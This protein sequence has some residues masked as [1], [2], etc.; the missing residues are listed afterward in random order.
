VASPLAELA[1]RTLIARTATPQFFP[2]MVAAAAL[3]ESLL[4]AVVAV[5]DD[6]IVG[7]IERYT[8]AR[9]KHS[10]YWVAKSSGE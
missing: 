2:S 6:R 9:E 7:N 1:N 10:A 8:R 4:A 3:V 5:G